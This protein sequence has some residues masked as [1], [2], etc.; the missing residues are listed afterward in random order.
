MATRL[1]TSRAAFPRAQVESA[2]TAWWDQRTGSALARRRAPEECRR[3][4]G[5]VF[6][7][8]P[9]ISFI[10][11]VTVTAMSQLEALLGFDL[12]KNAIPRGGYNS[13]EQ[14]VRDVTARLE[15]EYAKHY[16][17]TGALGSKSV[18]R[19]RARD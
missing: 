3:L 9:A 6:D 4:G 16:G 14:F 7:I 15:N 5:T 12:G 11:T 18:K 10:E 2:L 1:K 8:Q 19:G 17:L 13:R